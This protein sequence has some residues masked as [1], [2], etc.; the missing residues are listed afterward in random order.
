MSTQVNP[1]H[2]FRHPPDAVFQALRPVTVGGITL[3]RGDLLPEDSPVRSMPTR[4]EQLCKQRVLMAVVEVQTSRRQG[5]AAKA[6]EPQPA[7]PD[8]EKMSVKEL[9]Q[10]ARHLGIAH[11]GNA[12]QLRKRIRSHLG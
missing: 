4:L 3:N 7:V 6:A 2:P 5:K 8:L 1:V 11:G 10:Y 12:A 9:G